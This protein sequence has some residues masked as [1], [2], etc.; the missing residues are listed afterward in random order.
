MRIRCAAHE[1]ISKPMI[2]FDSNC[3]LYTFMNLLLNMTPHILDVIVGRSYDQQTYD[4]FQTASGLLRQTVSWCQ[5]PLGKSCNHGW[6]YTDLQY[7]Y[8][9]THQKNREATGVINMLMLLW[10]KSVSSNMP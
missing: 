7:N 6:L 8:W 2:H 3:I 9:V 10:V 5:L 4:I 1:T